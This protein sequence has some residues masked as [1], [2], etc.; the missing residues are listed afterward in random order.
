MK[1][2][3]IRCRICT[4]LFK[5]PE[6]SDCDVCSDERFTDRSFIERIRA[7]L[8]SIDLDVM[9]CRAA[10]KTIRATDWFGPDHPDVSNQNAF[11]WTWGNG[12]TRIYLNPAGTWRLAAFRRL[13]SEYARKH[14]ESAAICLYDWDHSTAWWDAL[15][16]TAPVWTL[17]TRKR[18]QFSDVDVDRSQAFAFLGVP[19]ARVADQW[20]DI[21]RIFS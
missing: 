11:D 8:E 5:V 15:A 19:R 16:E 7:T 12:R 21:A 13:R 20:S 3:E 18:Y 9:S 2:K 4:R 14:F 1:K 17:L 6:N 10:Q